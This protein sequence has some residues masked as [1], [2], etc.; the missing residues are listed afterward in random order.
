MKPDFLN[1]TMENFNQGLIWE[2]PKKNAYQLCFLFYKITKTRE[3]L[4]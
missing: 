2:I 1:V 3:L 4:L